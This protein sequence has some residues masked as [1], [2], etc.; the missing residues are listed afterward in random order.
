MGGTFNPIHIGH[1]VLAQEA[2]YK[3]QLDNVI[4]IPNNRPPH[5]NHDE[6]IECG[7]NRL[8]MIKLAIRDNPF[9][10]VSEIELER[11]EISYTYDTVR[12]LLKRLPDHSFSFITGVDSIL[13]DSWHNFDKLLSLLDH[14]IAATR[15]GFNEELLEERM[16]LQGIVNVNKIFLL[17]IPGIDVSSTMIRRRIAQG[18]P[19]KYYLMP[20]VEQFIKEN[21][22][23]L[24]SP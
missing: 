17:K 16:K 21:N 1:L 12:L 5:R 20:E 23:Y 11:E 2:L 10:S 6:I 14:F 24:R 3:F 9:F 19:V 8:H 7:K 18:E 13:K 15:P 22:L 4:F